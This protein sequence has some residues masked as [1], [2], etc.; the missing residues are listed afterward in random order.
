MRKIFS[1]VTG[2]LL[3]LV[4][5]LSGA[6]WVFLAPLF[7]ADEMLAQIRVEDVV[8]D[9]CY[10]VSVDLTPDRKPEARKTIIERQSI[11]GDFL[12]LGYE[13][14]LPDKMFALMKK[15]G[16]VVT[17]LVA[18]EKKTKNQTGN[19]QIGRY[20]IALLETFREA[21][22]NLLKKTPMIKEITYDIRALMQKPKKGAVITYKLE[23][24]RQQVVVECTGCEE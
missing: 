23:A 13:F 24:L 16:I 17:N 21:M 7:Q 6:L 18:F 2:I 22:G 19:I 12:A 4:I 5:L 3:G 9:Q 1:Y 15:P 8:S 10:F 20:N 11:C 14:T